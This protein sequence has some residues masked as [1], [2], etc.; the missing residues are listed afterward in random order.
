M[1]SNGRVVKER[2]SKRLL[3]SLEKFKINLALFRSVVMM[4]RMT[5]EELQELLDLTGWSKRRLAEQLALS[6]D[7]VYRW[8]V[9]GNVPGGPATI[10]MRHWLAEAAKMRPFQMLPPCPTEQKRATTKVT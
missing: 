10:L 1:R 5:I 8:F 6:E 4:D 9:T 7:A 2:L 3:K